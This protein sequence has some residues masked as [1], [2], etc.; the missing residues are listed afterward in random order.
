M[1]QH[2]ID[3]LTRRLHLID[4]GVLRVSTNEEARIRRA[5]RAAQR[6]N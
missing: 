2:Q 6:A 4:L 3:T 5:L 1:N